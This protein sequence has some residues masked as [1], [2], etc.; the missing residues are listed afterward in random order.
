MNKLVRT[1]VK[2]LFEQNGKVG[3]WWLTEFKVLYHLK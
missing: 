1:V 3:W 2:E